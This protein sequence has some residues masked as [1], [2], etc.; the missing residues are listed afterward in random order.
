MSANDGANNLTNGNFQF[1]G[2][3]SAY[4]RFVVLDSAP[5]STGLCDDATLTLFE[6][7][8]SSVGTFSLSLLASDFAPSPDNDSAAALATLSYNAGVAALI[9]GVQSKLGG[10]TFSIA[11][12]G[13][14]DY[15]AIA[16][17]MASASKAA[18]STPTSS[19][20]ISS[21]SPRPCWASPSPPSVCSAAVVP[22]GFEDVG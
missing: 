4:T 10:V 7:T 2:G 20:A 3:F 17:V 11:D 6:T 14:T 5:V 8:G 12:F 15:A 9:G 18:H 22:N 16:G 1:A 21:P 19:P 13:V